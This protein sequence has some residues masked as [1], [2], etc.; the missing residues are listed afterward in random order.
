MPAK[1]TTRGEFNEV[2]RFDGGVGWI[3]HPEET[4]E[5]A[6]H[7]FATDDGVYVVDPVDA[8]GLDDRLAD[9]GDVAGVL[10]C[11]LFHRRDAAAVARR[12]D[13]P[14]LLPDFLTGLSDG[15]VDAPVER[16]AGGVGG[17]E[18]VRVADN[19]AWQ[20]AGLWDGE[21]LYV[22]DALGTADYFLAPGE[23]LAVIYLLRLTPPR[24]PLAGLSPERV[25]CGHGAGVHDSAEAALT[26]ALADART[27]LLPCL[28]H[29]L[30]D[31]LASLTAAVRT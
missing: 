25:L 16:V 30:R 20:E 18:F 15:D 22:P 1:V 7:A 6:S 8:A 13:V 14:V 26:A 9:L 17:Y 23:R 28:R 3:A 4:M 11:S 10:V 2:D 5:R 21:T 24:D 27:N 19:R 29:N 31:Q 12:H